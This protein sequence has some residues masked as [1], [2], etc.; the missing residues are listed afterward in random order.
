MVSSNVW[1]FA[2]KPDSISAVTGTSTLFAIREIVDIS[3][4][5]DILSPSA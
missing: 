3:V 1:R 5:R 2:P 4:D